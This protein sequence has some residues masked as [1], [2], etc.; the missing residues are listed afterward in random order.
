MEQHDGVVAVTGAAGYVGSRLLQ[1]LDE[2][3]QH[4][5][6][7]AFDARPLAFPI[8]NVAAYR[9]DVS[10]SIEETL[11]HH[12][13]TTLVHLAFDPTRGRNLARVAAIRQSNLAALRAVLDSCVR[14]RLRHFIYL[15][16]YTVY[17]P[18]QD[19]PVPLRDDAPLRPLPDFPYGYD[20]YLA[21]Q[22]IE[23]FTSA[24][25]EIKVTVLRS[26]IVL[27]PNAESPISKAL[28]RP[29]LLGVLD[30]NPPLQ[31]VYEDDLARIIAIVMDQELPGVFNV[32]GDGVV[33]YSEMADVIESRLISLPAIL[34]Y[35]LVQLTWNLG[36]QLESTA[37]GL[38]L[39]RYPMVLDTGKLRQATGYR[40]WHTSQETLTAF[41]NSCLLNR[42]LE[43]N[44]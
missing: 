20:K 43:L 10:E 1:K 12:Q 29:L 21:E 36:I 25:P 30:Y 33:F 32:A 6:I 15:S 4:R 28:F 9:K 11:L 24:H 35:P 23:E 22:M 26:C 17:G 38:D 34:A 8:H 2:N 37:S 16:S 41:A 18:H 42:E 3:P 7:I 44:A 5:Q 31:F 40:F 13:V 14:A 27:G 19:N 39:V